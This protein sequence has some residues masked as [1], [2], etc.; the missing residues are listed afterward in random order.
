MT[1]GNLGNVEKADKC[2]KTISWLI[3][4]ILK[5]EENYLNKH[6]KEHLY[7]WETVRD[8]R[9]SNFDWNQHKTREIF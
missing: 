8:H 5:Y 1:E 3:P 9:L 6:E 7:E 2:R 4:D